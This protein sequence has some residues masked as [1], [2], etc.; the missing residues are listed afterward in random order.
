MSKPEHVKSR[1][2]NTGKEAWQRK[3]G[4]KIG[5]IA[6]YKA[7]GFEQTDD[8]KLSLAEEK[9]DKL[10][11]MKAKRLVR[12]RAVDDAGCT[13]AEL[14]G[15]DDDKGTSGKKSK[16]DIHNAGSGLSTVNAISVDADFD[17]LLSQER[18]K[19]S[20]VVFT[21]EETEAR[22]AMIDADFFLFS[23][24]RLRPGGE[25]NIQ[26]VAAIFR[27]SFLYRWQNFTDDMHQ[28]SQREAASAFARWNTKYAKMPFKDGCYMGIQ[29]HENTPAR[30]PIMTKEDEEE[31]PETTNDTQEVGVENVKCSGEKKSKKGSHT[32]HEENT[33]KTKAK[34]KTAKTT[35]KKE[36]TDRTDCSKV[37][38]HETTNETKKKAKSKSDGKQKS[39]ELPKSFQ[40]KTIVDI[41]GHQ[42][43][44]P[45]ESKRKV[46]TTR[47]TE[48]LGNE[49]SSPKKPIKSKTKSPKKSP[50]SKR[51]DSS[52]STPGKKKKTA[53]NKLP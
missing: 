10:F 25:C 27:E 17:T 23:N 41:V 20:K 53:S 36:A 1:V 12:T 18:K 46:K 26:E 6:F 2:I 22:K 39:E 42:E 16:S 28:L 19:T 29:L 38:R 47:A 7:C 30:L 50:S 44:N 33:K 14:N 35:N 4:Q 52:E 32:A 45:A 24:Y 31:P 49:E 11:F 21:E 8:G 3:V 5:G 34:S 9:V 15:D 43:G 13:E 40:K 48:E 37:D 51:V